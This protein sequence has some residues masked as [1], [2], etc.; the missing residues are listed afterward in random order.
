[1]KL[2]EKQKAAVAAILDLTDRLRET[3]LRAAA[4]DRRTFLRAQSQWGPRQWADEAVR[5]YQRFLILK[6]LH[7]DK[8]LRPDAIVDDLWHAHI[9]DT[10]A[11]AE[12]CDRIFGA[13]LHHD[14]S[15]TDA[16]RDAEAFDLYC[17]TFVRTGRGRPNPLLAGLT[18]APSQVV[19]TRDAGCETCA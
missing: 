3:A 10:R 7:P 13:F 17:A 14:P 12:D 19:R 6:A 15:V 11:Y 18:L 9:L 2:N 5:E 16:S 4:K 8:I 1:M